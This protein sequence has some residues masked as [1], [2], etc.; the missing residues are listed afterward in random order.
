MISA[1]PPLQDVWTIPNGRSSSLVPATVA[2]SSHH[3]FAAVK[4]SAERRWISARP[5]PLS[6]AHHRGAFDF[7]FPLMLTSGNCRLDRPGR[8]CKM[9]G[10]SLTGRPRVVHKRLRVGAF[11]KR[12]VPERICGFSALQLAGQIVEGAAAEYLNEDRLASKAPGALHPRQTAPLLLV[13]AQL[14]CRVRLA[15]SRSKT[16]ARA[17]KSPGNCSLA[18]GLRL[19]CGC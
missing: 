19:P 13:R 2:S 5:A 12:G 4:T 15:L 8:R 10:E 9:A 17:V 1:K 6:R 14:R 7:N 11:F 18:D 16:N 3:A